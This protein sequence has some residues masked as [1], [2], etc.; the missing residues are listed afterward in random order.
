MKLFSIQTRH[1]GDVLKINSIFTWGRSFDPKDIPD[2]W[3]FIVSFPLGITKNYT[4]PCSFKP[5]I[6]K[7]YYTIMFRRRYKYEQIFVSKTWRPL[8]QELANG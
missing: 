1:E 8:T 2:G 5:K 4:D 7:C 6:G 3:Y